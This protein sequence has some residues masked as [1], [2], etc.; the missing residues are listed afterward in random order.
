MQCVR[1]VLDTNVFVAGVVWSGPPS[2]ILDMWQRGVVSLVVTSEILDEYE[3]VARRLE[4]K[5][6]GVDFSPAFDLLILNSELC[7]SV[8]L[9]ERVCEDSHDD[10]FLACALENKANVVISGDRHLLCVSGYRGVQVLKPRAFLDSYQIA[11][12]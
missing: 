7:A 9:P 3:R 10:K 6:S 4:K 12:I 5:Y 11:T 1:V 8:S 2:V